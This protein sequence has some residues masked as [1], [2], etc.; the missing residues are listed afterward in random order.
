M[1]ERQERLALSEWE[2]D[3]LKILHEVAAGHLKQ[4]QGAAQ[5]GL[6]E[7]DFRKLLKRYRDH[8]DAA[9]PHGLRGRASNRRLDEDMAARAIAAVE[10]QY[11]DFGPTLATEYLRKD[12]GLAIAGKACAD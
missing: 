9:V 6:S 3:R 10:R 12:A 2:R 7:R 8:G 4:R 1:A 5:C 11:R